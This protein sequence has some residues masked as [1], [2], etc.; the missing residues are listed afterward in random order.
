MSR[1]IAFRAWHQGRKEWLHDKSWG[2]C[3]ILG[4]TIWAFG[5]WCRVPLEELNDVVVEQN[6]GLKDRHGVDI[7]EG[8]TLKGTLSVMGGPDIEWCG[9]VGWDEMRARFVALS[10]AGDARELPLM[11]GCEVCGNVHEETRQ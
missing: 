8:D 4:E 2:G 1:T 5:E 6:T 10:N 9:T 3:H 11:G 7:Y